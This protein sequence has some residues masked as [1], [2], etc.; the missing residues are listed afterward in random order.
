MLDVRVHFRKHRRM[1]ESSIQSTVARMTSQARITEDS[2]GINTEALAKSSSDVQLAS[3][4]TPI[5]GSPS[6]NTDIPSSEVQ[7]N[8][9]ESQTHVP[10]ENLPN[11]SHQSPVEGMHVDAG[12]S[13]STS[14][15]LFRWHAE[16]S[17]ALGA[18]SNVNIPDSSVPN[19]SIDE[20][21][22]ESRKLRI[23]G[24]STSAK[25]RDVWLNGM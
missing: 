10:M 24:P 6:S 3:A 23:L 17:Q 13:Q 18:T 4:N 2:G 15:I 12:P 7:P 21:D 8:N 16:R 14:S 9:L 19:T 25:Q 5:I 1:T 11:I 20:E 22:E